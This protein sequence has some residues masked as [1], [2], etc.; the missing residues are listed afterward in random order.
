[1]RSTSPAPGHTRDAPAEGEGH[2][3]PGSAAA[4][5]PRAPPAD[6]R[7]RRR[8]GGGGSPE[9]EG[10]GRPRLRGSVRP[11]SWGRGGHCRRCPRPPP[12]PSLSASAPWC[13]AR[14]GERVRLNEGA[15]GVQ[16]QPLG[17][18]RG[19]SSSA[20]GEGSLLRAPR[21]GNGPLR[22]PAPDLPGASGGAPPARALSLPGPAPRAGPAPPPPPLPRLTPKF[23]APRADTLRARSQPLPPACTAPR[24]PIPRDP[25][26]RSSAQRFPPRPGSCRR[27][28]HWSRSGSG[29]RGCSPELVG[30]GRGPGAAV[31]QSAAVI[32]PPGQCRWGHRRPP[33]RGETR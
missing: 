8:G 27:L 6:P 7:P 26:P 11:R 5:R 3:A 25:G 24:P 10:E 28:P 32:A 20:N 4:R 13:S 33:E 2:A 21:G 30:W 19:G 16:L 29:R 18:Q 23:P 14:P 9:P 1:M 31:L 12:P 17:P 15:G 22:A